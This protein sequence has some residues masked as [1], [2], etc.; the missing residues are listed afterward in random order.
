MLNMLAQCVRHR[1]ARCVL[2]MPLPRNM[3]LAK[4]S[5]MLLPWRANSNMSGAARFKKT[6]GFDILK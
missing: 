5:G 6:C 4:G 2:S 1:V 3:M